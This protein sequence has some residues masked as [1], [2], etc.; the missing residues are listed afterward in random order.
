MFQVYI[1]CKSAPGTSHFKPLL[2]LSS[3]HT[4]SHRPRE[5]FSVSCTLKV[6]VCPSSDGQTDG[7]KF[8]Q[9]LPQSS[10]AAQPPL[11]KPTRDCTLASRALLGQTTIHRVVLK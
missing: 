6:K 4:L 11:E 1:V 7:Q 10:L 8:S 3:Y 9:N 5:S 2:P